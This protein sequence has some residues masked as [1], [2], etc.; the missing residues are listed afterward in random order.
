MSLQIRVSAQGGPKK[1]HIFHLTISLEPL[2]IKRCG[3][4]RNVP[5]VSQ[6][7]DWVAF[8]CSCL[9]ILFKLAP[10]YYTENVNVSVY[11]HITQINHEW[12]RV[13]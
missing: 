11:Y 2:K 6:N 13:I 7:K 4:H 8:L 12:H 9:K 10:S 1:Y 5:R 3:F